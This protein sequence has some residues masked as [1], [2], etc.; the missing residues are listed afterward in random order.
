M[1]DELHAALRAAL[2]AGKRI[3]ELAE[4]KAESEARGMIRGRGLVYYVDNTG[5]FNERM[6][7]RFDPSGTV[8]V[9]SGVLSKETKSP[10]LNPAA[11]RSFW[12]WLR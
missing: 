6:E 3:A 11:M 5:I 12:T 9:I 2:D 7:I 10:T 8:T 1:D 4:R